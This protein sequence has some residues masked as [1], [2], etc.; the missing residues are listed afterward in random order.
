[1]AD[2]GENLN[3]AA[4]FFQSTIITFGLAYVWFITNLDKCSQR[5]GELKEKK[6]FPSL[7]RASADR[8]EELDGINGSCIDET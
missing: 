2:G 6:T 7:E 8:R 5:R 4:D 3:A 1:M